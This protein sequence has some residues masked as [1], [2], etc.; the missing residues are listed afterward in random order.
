MSFDLRLLVGGSHDGE[1]E[2]VNWL[3]IETLQKVKKNQLKAIGP[4]EAP[5]PI[6]YEYY[7]RRHLGGGTFSGTVVYVLESLDDD[8]MV[9][10]LVQNY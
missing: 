5:H 8:D 3:T 7:T 4:N 2:E 1:R 10:M 6:E 9:E